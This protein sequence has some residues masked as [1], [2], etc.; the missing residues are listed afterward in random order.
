VI[1]SD[2]VIIHLK[3]IR[4]VT[5]HLTI[6]IQTQ[7]L[8]KALRYWSLPSSCS[9]SFQRKLWRVTDAVSFIALSVAGFARCPLRPCEC[10]VH[11]RYQIFVFRFAHF[12]NHKIEAQQL[13]S[14]FKRFP[15]SFK[16][17]NTVNVFA[18]K[19]AKLTKAF[20]T[21]LMRS[22]DNFC[23]PRSVITLNFYKQFSV[24]VHRLAFVTPCT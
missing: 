20:T 1:R 5:E 6:S 22:S 13:Y 9:V 10:A 16:S 3:E 14:R 17:E 7:D 15:R 2:C 21:I 19:L 18:C 4:K 12:S 8:S 23:I 11:Q 24:V